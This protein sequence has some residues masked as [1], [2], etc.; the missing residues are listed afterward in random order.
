MYIAETK[1]IALLV[2]SYIMHSYYGLKGCSVDR[3][4]HATDHFDFYEEKPRNQIQR[5][6][7]T[8]TEACKNVS[9]IVSCF[10]T[11]LERKHK[12]LVWGLFFHN[13]TTQ[14]VHH[15]VLHGPLNKPSY[16]KPGLSPHSRHS[17]RARSHGYK[18]IFNYAGAWTRGPP[19]THPMLWDKLKNH[20]YY[21]LLLIGHGKPEWMVFPH[22]C[23]RL[24]I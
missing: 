20:T 1:L 10:S 3:C 8:I 17:S 5:P 21:H 15:P 19:P 6:K 18:E 4:K 7:K 9:H 24:K 16:S 13:R 2:F 23:I 14:H 22:D 12:V 11:H